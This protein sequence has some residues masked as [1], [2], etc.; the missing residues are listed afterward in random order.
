MNYLSGVS[1]ARFLY[2]CLVAA[3][4]SGGCHSGFG[5]VSSSPRAP[6]SV[7]GGVLRRMFHKVRSPSGQGGLH[8]RQDSRRRSGRSSGH[9]QPATP[10]NRPRP[11]VS[12]HA[13]VGAGTL[14]RQRRGRHPPP[15]P[16]SRGTNGTARRPWDEPGYLRL[17][18]AQGRLRDG[19]LWPRDVSAPRTLV[20]PQT[21]YPSSRPATI[22]GDMELMS[23]L[24]TSPGPGPKIFSNECLT[25][26]RRT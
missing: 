12:W 8:V 7:T 5:Q 17:H 1:Y 26:I 10:C 4:G 20:R 13:T 24:P 25:R 6:F 23:T 19:V 14:A 2:A 15:P 22:S 9:S 18:R 21:L 16:M 3:Q 11:P